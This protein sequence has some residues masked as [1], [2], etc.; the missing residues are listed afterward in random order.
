[1]LLEC[2]CVWLLLSIAEI[3]LSPMWFLLDLEFVSWFSDWLAY[4]KICLVLEGEKSLKGVA[5]IFLP[6]YQ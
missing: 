6:K 2:S 1:M 5:F 4:S 3:F